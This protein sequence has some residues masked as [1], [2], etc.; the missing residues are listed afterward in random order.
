MQLYYFYD[1]SSA[2]SKL[3]LYPSGSSGIS[4]I[5]NVFQ[6]K[7]GNGN[8]EALGEVVLATYTD[9]GSYSIQIYTNLKDKSNPVS[10]TP[11]FANPVTFYQ[12]HAGIST[13]EVP[14]VNLMNGTLYSVVITNIG[15]DTVEYLCETNSAYDWVEFQAGLEENQSFCYHEKNGWSD[16]FKTSPSACVRIKAH[17]RTLSNAVNVTRPASFQAA[18]RAYNQISLTWS[19]AAGVSGYQI[20]RRTS[21]GEYQKVETASW[22]DTSW[23]DTKVQP[24]ITY[25]YKIRAYSMVNGTAKYS[26]YTAEAAAKTM[27]ATPSVSVKVSSGLYNT[28]NWNKISG[29]AGYVVYRKTSSGKWTKLANI[30]KAATTSYKDK[31][32]K[33]TTVYE[34]TVRAYCTVDKKTVASSYKSSGKYKSA[35]SRQTVSSV[36]NTKKGLKLKWKAQK[37][38]DGY[39]IYKKT[40]S[41]KYKLAATIKK[42]KTSTWTD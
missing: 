9:G 12:E 15:S 31:K 11:A 22:S 35:P 39:Y 34:Y 13:V 40:G 17:T 16:F 38:C 23:T 42:G 41:G 5:A 37:K 10:G 14:E 8:G 24:G 21:G 29:A 32:I 26:D 19:K 3:K 2:L 33:S 36:S 27:L 25:T 7:A 6:A 4:S 18:A 30:K 20:Y 1:G 28:V